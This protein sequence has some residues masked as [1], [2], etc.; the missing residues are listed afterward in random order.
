[1]NP[2]SWKSSARLPIPAFDT[3]VESD[4]PISRE[5]ID[6]TSLIRVATGHEAT[7]GTLD[8]QSRRLWFNTGGLL[9]RSHFRG[10]DTISSQFEDF[11]GVHI[12]REIDVLSAG[13]LAMRINVASITTAQTLPRKHSRYLAVIGN[14]SS[15]MRPVDGSILKSLSTPKNA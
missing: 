5:T 8:T 13:K 14:G 9:L 3:F 7:D 10:L 1:M 6:G 2:C 12:A 4:W 11:H 15:G